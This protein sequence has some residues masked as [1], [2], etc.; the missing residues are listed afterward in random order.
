MYL[1]IQELKKEGLKI[2]Q[3]YKINSPLFLLYSI[4]NL[5]YFSYDFIAGCCLSSLL[6][7]AT[8]P[9]FFVFI[10][11][12][13]PKL[14]FFFYH[15]YLLFFFVIFLSLRP[16]LVFFS[17]LRF[18]LLLYYCVLVLIFIAVKLFFLLNTLHN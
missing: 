13:I 16:D 2:Y 9:F 8:K 4:S 14:V 5:T 7:L 17:F 3:F 6:S 11:S 10:F 1:F 12:I 15:I 18:L